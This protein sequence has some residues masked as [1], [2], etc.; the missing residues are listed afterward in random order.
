[1]ATLMSRV[2]A[3][4]T[5]RVIMWPLSTTVVNTVGLVDEIVDYVRLCGGCGVNWD[6]GQT[7]IDKACE[8]VRAAFADTA[9]GVQCGLYVWYRETIA[10]IPATPDVSALAAAL[11]TFDS[12]LA[13]ANVGQAGDD[14][15][16]VVGTAIDQENEAAVHRQNLSNTAKEQLQA[17]QNATYDLIESHFGIAPPQYGLG[18]LATDTT[19]NPSPSNPT[20]VGRYYPV[21]YLLAGGEHPSLTLQHYDH[22]GGSYYSAN[23]IDKMQD[24]LDWARD[25]VP[26]MPHVPTVLCYRLFDGSIITDPIGNAYAAAKM[27][28]SQS[29]VAMVMAYPNAD[30]APSSGD[31]ITYADLDLWGFHF[32]SAWHVQDQ[33]VSP[34]G[35]TLMSAVNAFSEKRFYHY[36]ASET[37]LAADPVVPY[38]SDL[39][40]LSGG[41][42]VP[43]TASGPAILGACRIVRET[44]SLTADNVECGIYLYIPIALNALGDMELDADALAALDDFDAALEAANTG[45]EPEDVVSILGTVVYITEVGAT[46]RDNLSDG[47]KT[48]LQ[49]YQNGWYDHLCSRY[50]CN[51][52]FQMLGPRSSSNGWDPDGVADVGDQFPVNYL[53]TVP[54][55]PALATQR[56]RYITGQFYRNDDLTL[57][58]T[59][60]WDW[61]LLIDATKQMVPWLQMMTS[62]G[63]TYPLENVND[64]GLAIRGDDRVDGAGC[65]GAF[66]DSGVSDQLC[67]QWM[68]Q[69]LSGWHQVADPPDPPP[70]PP[71][72]AEPEPETA[73]DPDEPATADSRGHLIQRIEPDRDNFARSFRDCFGQK[74]AA[75]A[76]YEPKLNTELV[77]MGDQTG[78]GGRRYVPLLM[79]RRELP[80]VSNI[81]QA[82]LRLLPHDT[83]AAADLSGIQGTVSWIPHYDDEPPPDAWRLAKQNQTPFALTAWT[84]KTWVEIDVTDIVTGVL[85][86]LAYPDSSYLT[87]RLDWQGAEILRFYGF[88]AD[89]EKAPQLTVDFG[90]LEVERDPYTMVYDCLWA[91]LESHYQFANLVRRGN[92]IKWSTN[93]RDPEKEALMDSD[94][95]I[96]SI[97]M[98][99]SAPHP[100]AT[101]TSSVDVIRIEI[102][103]RTGD[104][105]L[106]YRHDPLRWA[107]YRALTHFAEYLY[108]LRWHGQQIVRLARPTTITE[109]MIAGP[110]S[111]NLKGWQCL[112]SCEVHMWWN[113]ESL[114]S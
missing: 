30:P 89:A 69:L 2:T 26:Q 12:R 101:S 104:K 14:T 55:V 10:S 46:R 27:L 8:Y 20:A 59:T 95:P 86:T 103:A 44:K 108:A 16:E 23:D 53:K 84:R 66:G 34:A 79:F 48:T 7:A 25:I 87:L 40:R 4:S 43:Y 83:I 92:R 65:F 47:D 24:M 97:V 63:W 56:Y 37:Y 114:R 111:G 91:R 99:S 62:A 38:M 90:Y 51:V 29:D 67:D 6:A 94:V 35:P 64:I 54:E 52:L 77:I 72:G 85:S 58:L 13:T 73:A 96:V 28:V 100:H 45:V 105:R 102:Q 33:P 57:T 15:V 1:M 113:S 5:K 9:P 112:W 82:T 32:F 107:I 60:M 11:A 74:E 21:N 22:I 41:I 81:S 98:Q 18:P 88:E 36:P 78:S 76:E 110:E 31:P 61:A 109:G 80:S 3:R 71:P 50:V 42:S 39:A 49:N 70:D 19:W 106:Q 93:D 17:Y 68:Y 75:G